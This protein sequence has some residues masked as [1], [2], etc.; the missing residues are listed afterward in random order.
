MSD[1]NNNNN[2]NNETV[3]PKA[4]GFWRIWAFTGLLALDAV[5]AVLILT[6]LI[7]W[8]RHHEGESDT[9]HFTFAGSLVDLA[10]LAFLRLL[11]A[12]TGLLVAY[13]KA[14]SIPEYPFDLY[15]RNGEKKSRD[16]LDQEALEEPFGP[17]FRRYFTRPSFATELLAI[18][19]Q[20][21]CIVK[22]LARMN[23][24]IGTLMDVEPVHP[25]FWLAVLSTALLSVVE[26]SYHEP[27][28]KLAGECGKQRL[29]RE[30]A[31]AT[32]SSS[33]SASLFRQLSSTLSLPLLA[34]NALEHAQ[35]QGDDD[36]E[37]RA[38][39]GGTAGASS[40]DDT[41]S[42]KNDSPGLSD[43]TS[44]TDYRAS[45]K[46][47]VSTV[48]PDLGWIA[49]A[50]VFLIL[51]AVAQVYIPRFL[52][53]ILDSLAATFSDA[54]DDA[55]RHTSMTQVPGFMKNIKLL[56]VAS[57]LAGVFAG[58]RGSIF[59][60]V[61]GRVNVRLRVQ[62]M[63]SLLAQDIGFFDVAKTGEITSRLSSDTTLVG[64]QVSLNVNVFLRSLVQA[65]GVLLFMFIVSW[66]LSILAF[67][68]V[69][70]I[71]LL[72]KQYS[73]YITKVIKTMQKSLADGNAVSEAALGSMST[74]RA[75][76]AAEGELKRFETEMKKYLRFNLHTA[77]AYC[78]YAM[79]T[80]A[81][82]QLVFAVVGE[83]YV[84][85]CTDCYCLYYSCML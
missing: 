13:V 46:D 26:A 40:D 7:P 53:N 2:D 27:A 36:E 35:Q 51:A 78:G 75:H 5:T 38:A 30:T 62:L 60:V 56:V 79:M 84:D 85:D 45:W 67:I 59:T 20:V 43:I 9:D 66:Q 71:T 25:I 47:L 39:N 18:G 16:E 24:E 29:G 41:E 76:D 57:V 80:T 1:N 49:I 70:V 33:H 63:D 73:A 19:T 50:F 21:V 44:D 11:V 4:Q 68:S 82:P 12:T 55:T 34:D 3:T 52:G 23:V 81:F 48:T 28:C 15:H 54:D 17:F 31:E 14:E 83:C 64:D 6:P 42:H 22:C 65:I 32:S 58:L 8:V 37:G 69:P 74:I 10:A 72:S 61:G 77:T